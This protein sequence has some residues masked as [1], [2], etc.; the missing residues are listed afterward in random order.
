MAAE[1]SRTSSLG[2]EED[3][4]HRGGLARRRRAVLLL[5]A[6]GA[7]L[8]DC[9]AGPRVLSGYRS[10][11]G[12]NGL[13]RLAPH[14]G[15]DLAA[16][17]GAP[18][19]AAA[20]GDVESVEYDPAGCGLGVLLHHGPFHRFTVYCHLSRSVVAAGQRVRR[21]QVIGRVGAT[22]NAGEVP[23]LHWQVCVSACPSGHRDGLLAGTEDPARYLRGCYD[24]TTKH[25]VDRLVLTQPLACRGGTRNPAARDR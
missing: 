19:L 9:I 25:L 5:A 10:L 22:G 20:A 3:G 1:P 2:A 12:V 4:R 6:L 21:G 14:A 8:G 15:I 24:P 23:H 11:V 7:L 18:V 16:A 17:R 13:E